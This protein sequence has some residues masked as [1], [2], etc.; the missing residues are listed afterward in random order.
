[1]RLQCSRAD[2]VSRLKNGGC[3]DVIEGSRLKR[4]RRRRRAR[5]RECGHLHVNLAGRRAREI[6]ECAWVI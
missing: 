5:G 3:S 2:G 1:M 6:R 4:R